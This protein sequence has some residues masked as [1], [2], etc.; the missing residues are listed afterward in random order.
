M[1]DLEIGRNL[2]LN[3]FVSPVTEKIMS[4]LFKAKPKTPTEL[5]KLTKESISKLDTTHGENKKVL[6]YRFNLLNKSN[7]LDQRRNQQEFGSDEE[8]TVWRW[9]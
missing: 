2:V 6:I 7:R 1:A 4:F 5:V 3:F 9:R 8:H